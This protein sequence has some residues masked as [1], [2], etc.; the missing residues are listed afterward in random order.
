MTH[1]LDDLDLGTIELFAAAAELGSI[2]KAASRFHLSQPV[3]SR[4]LR[5]LEQRLGF[6]V[7]HRSAVGVT[8]SPRG[9]HALT[10]ARAFLAGARQFQEETDAL[11]AGDG[12]VAVMATAN[13]VRHDLPAVAADIAT[14]AVDSGR[15][16]PGMRLSIGSTLDISRAVRADQADIGLTDGP[17]APLGL[18]SEVLAVHDL[19]TVV[20]VTHPLAARSTVA[21]EDLA[22]SS[23]Q[24]PPTGTGTRDVIDA[25]FERAGL[26]APLALGSIGVDQRVTLAI[27]GSGPTIVRAE[28]VVGHLAAGW[29]VR[30]EVASP[31]ARR[32]RPPASEDQPAVF[33]Q[34]VRLVWKGHRPTRAAAD[35]IEAIRSSG[36]PQ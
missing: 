24:L 9:M 1:P 10:A 16:Q 17:D 7:F 19:A 33:R 21:L 8:L 22:A 20:G 14:S 3:A 4:R 36:R 28:A 27:M 13:V 6:E 11:A 34:P 32:G 26:A 31:T 15:R 18:E 5:D 30:I 35:V 2:S 25:A 12:G 23:L 29:L